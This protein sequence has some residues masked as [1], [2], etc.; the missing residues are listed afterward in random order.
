LKRIKV[1]VTTA[2]TTNNIGA[3]ISGIVGEGVR[4]SFVED[5]DCGVDEGDG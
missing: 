3:V 5:V 1:T 2:K 4:S